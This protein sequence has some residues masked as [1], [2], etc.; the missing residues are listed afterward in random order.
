MATI[1]FS[2]VSGGITYSRTFPVIKLRG[3]DD[4]D[5]VKF[6]PAFQR[7]M[8]DGSTLEIIKGFRRVFTVTLGALNVAADRQFFLNFLQHTTRIVQYSNLAGVDCVLSN[9]TSFENQWLYDTKLM[10]YFEVELEENAIYTVWPSLVQPTP[11]TDLYIKTKVEITGTEASPQTLTTNTA[12]LATDDTG[13]A[14]PAINLAFYAVTIIVTE[15]QDSLV[16][17]V[18]D[19][20]QSGSD[21][22]FQLAHSDVGNPYS[23]G[24]WYCTITIGLQAK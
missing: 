2:Y 11:D 1:N 19:I 14:Y 16:N 20:T 7:E 4:P 21:I 9:P 18:G 15:Y 10:K 3:L 23:D 12:P 6:F 8:A 13:A 22:S 5:K 24:K 17:R